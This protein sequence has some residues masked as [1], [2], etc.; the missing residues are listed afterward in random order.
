MTDEDYDK[1]LKELGA[2]FYF[3]NF[4]Y[5]DLLAFVIVGWSK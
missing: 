5:L 1:P 2:Q 3:Y 4:F